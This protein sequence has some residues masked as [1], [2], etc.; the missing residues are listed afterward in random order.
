[1]WEGV[2]G[3][4]LGKE[5]GRVGRELKENCS[6][7]VVRMYSSRGSGKGGGIGCEGKWKVKPI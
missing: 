4:D 2:W 1:M 3:G 6:Q 5:V 7:N